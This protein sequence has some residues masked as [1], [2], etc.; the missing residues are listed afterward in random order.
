[1]PRKSKV[2]GRWQIVIAGEATETQVAFLTDAEVWDL[3]GSVPVSP[4]PHTHTTQG[5]STGTTDDG[6]NLITLRDAVGLCS[7]IT[8]D[9][10]K[11]RRD[12]ARRTG[13]GP[14]PRG[15][16]GRSETYDPAEF[17][18]WLESESLIEENVR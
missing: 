1:M 11:K 5:V 6:D 18:A 4:S 12:R 13:G 16:R 3:I 9:A 15:Q 2:R 14:R 10:L 17:T 8:Y 7:G